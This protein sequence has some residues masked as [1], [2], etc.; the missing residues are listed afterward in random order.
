MAGECGFLLGKNATLVC[1]GDSITESPNGYVTVMRNLITAGYPERNIRVVNAGISGNRVTDMVA[2]LERDVIS[3]KPN[4]VT[5]NVGVND[6]WHSFREWEPPREIPDGS[7]QNGVPLTV[8]EEALG[9]M[10]DTL[11]ESTDAEIVLL[12]PT[13]IGEDVDNPENLANARLEQYAAAMQRVAESR[14]ALLAPTHDDFVMAIRAGRSVNPEFRLT[15]D[16][17]HMNSV[18]D[19][20]VARTVLAAL[21][22]AGLGAE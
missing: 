15:T 7:G 8:Y 20:V 13:V 11:R 3:Q 22:F 2:R 16:G 17:V 14:Q 6:V 19:H 10:V 1:L 12:T 9:F 4:C 5:I 21:G 18:G